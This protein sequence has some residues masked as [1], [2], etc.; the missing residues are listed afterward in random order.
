VAAR[1]PVR[2]RLGDGTVVRGETEDIGRDGARVAATGVPRLFRGERVAVSL[3]PFPHDRAP[4][5]AEVGVLAGGRVAR[6]GRPPP[7]P[8]AA[9][10]RRHRPDRRRRDRAGR[11][12]RMGGRP[13]PRR[14]RRPAVPERRT[15][16]TAARRM[17]GAAAVLAVALAAQELARAAPPPGAE[18]APSPDALVPDGLD[19]VTASDG[20]SPVRRM[21]RLGPS[22]AQRASLSPALEAAF[23]ARADE[24]LLGAEIHV[25]IAPTPGADASQAPAIELSV[26]D[27]RVALLP[28]E[29]VARG[30]ARAIPVPPGLLAPRNRLAVRMVPQGGGCGV[31]PGGWRRVRAL[32]IALD[33]APVPLPDDLALLPLPFLDRGFDESATV[34][35]VLAA[36]PTPERVRLASLVAGWLALE[37]PV[38][39]RFEAHAGDLPASG[40]VVLVDDPAAAE[41]LGVAAPG[42]PSI[43]M[44]D[45]PRHPDSNVKLVVVAGRDPGEL[46]IAVE[47]LASGT[48]RLAGHEVPLAAVPAAPAAAPYSAPRWI[49][50]GRVV[51]FAD[52][53]GTA[54]LSHQGTDP[55]TLSRR[56]R[57]A[58]DLWIWPSDFVLLDLGWTEHI[59]PG[60]PA[61]RLDV[62]LNGQYLATLPRSE[63]AGE[64]ARR[65]RLRVPREHVRGFDELLVHVRY[66]EHDPCAVPAPAERGEP[67]RVAISGDS[68]LHVEG[69]P[70][71]AAQP[72][73]A[74]F[75]Y[76]GWPFTRLPDL[77]ETTVVLPESPSAAELSIVLSV[78]GRLAQ[79]TGRAGAG[80]AFVAGARVTDEDLAGRDLLVVGADGD[81]PVLSRWA[82]RFPIVIDREGARVRRPAVRGATLGLLGGAGPLLDVRRAARALDGAREVAAIAGIESPVTPGRT[83]VAITA[84]TRDGFPP[85]AEF[86]GHAESRGRTGDLLLLAGG[87]RAMFRIGPAFHRGELD[88]WTR[89]RWFLAGHWLVLV[90]AIAAGALLLARVLRRLLDARMRERLA[91]GEGAG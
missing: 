7:G 15:A 34:P 65:I 88:P 9:R 81:D 36:P 75:A 18:E 61:P 86:L 71:F 72:D 77:S 12:G 63:G 73:V 26:N 44:V 58:P 40:A 13:A 52:M 19:A 38:P 79:V 45:H 69:L 62:E 43:R 53:P 48:A 82:E 24:E 83:V 42:G 35:I 56:F 39:L 27:G 33:S 11:A 60:A 4:I 32:G 64:R 57:V 23:G 78:M 6:L 22:D 49:P 84:S 37:A 14:G 55:A 50:P 90:P 10:A 41:R 28:P 87:R 80:A 31:G 70:H 89:F 54:Q 25:D 16:V 74:L 91:T 29:D 59:P 68:V 76:D 2:L 5:A 17:A 20:V 46:R 85:L 8:A 66:P 51:P 30:G 67:P 3:R 1:V 21:L 47:R